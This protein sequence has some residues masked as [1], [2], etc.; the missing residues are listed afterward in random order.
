MKP[1]KTGMHSRAKKWL[2]RGDAAFKIHDRFLTLWQMQADLFYPE[3]ATFLSEDPDPAT[4][5]DGIYT[6]K[7][8]ILSRTLGE[9][10]GSMTRAKGEQW[11][12]LTALPEELM[13]QDDVKSWCEDATKRQRNVLYAGASGFSVAMGLADRD[14]ATFGNAVTRYAYN[15][16]RD[17]VYFSHAMLRDCAWAENSEGIV[18]EMHERM[19]PTLAQARDLPGVGIE[20]LPAAWRKKLEDPKL[21]HEKVEI[22]R[23]VAPVD[24]YSYGEDEKPRA[25]AKFASIY[26]ACGADVKDEE[27]ALGEGFLDHFPYS[28]RRWMRIPGTPYARS[29]ATGVALADGSTLNTAEA[30]LLKGIEQKVSPP[31]V[32]IDDGIVGPISLGADEITFVDREYMQAGEKAIESL[33][34]GDPKYGMEYV[35]RKAAEMAIA[36]F[37]NLLQMPDREMTATEWRQRFKNAQR[38]AAPVFEPIEGDYSIM[39]D[40][41]FA[42][43]VGAHGPADPWGLFLPAPEALNGGQVRYEFETAL[44]EAFTDLV[45]TNALDVTQQYLALKEAQDPSADVFQMDK[46]NRASLG[47]FKSDWIRPEKEVDDLRKQRAAQ[48]A[49]TKQENQAAFAAQTAARANPENV[50]MLNQ[51]LQDGQPAP[52]GAPA[53]TQPGGNA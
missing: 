22:R 25:K 13:D 39:M 29:P 10:I 48:A 11:F 45:R 2:E 52:V 16:N 32:A 23:C 21:A 1:D 3:M 31:R 37:M 24:D 17:G 12:K 36:C 28:V 15:K 6:S 9:R 35:D 49:Q 5:Y 51:A 7:P 30:A 44:S 20:N 8:Q 19:K 34:V 53:P 33:E 4:V 18:D 42:L 43:C 26:I 46:I 14:Y 38:D 41:V 40:G 27:R 47:N 50:K